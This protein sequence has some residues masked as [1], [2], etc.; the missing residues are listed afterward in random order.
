MPGQGA[1]KHRDNVWPSS[2]LGDRLQTEFTIQ[3]VQ[4]TLRRDD[5]HMIRTEDQSFGDEFHRHICVPRKNL[6]QQCRDR[7]QMIYDDDGY[8]H[9]CRQVME[10]SNIGIETA[11]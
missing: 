8:A 6:V 11:R 9:I 5:E 2:G 1:E 4:I 7:S 10:Q 3:H